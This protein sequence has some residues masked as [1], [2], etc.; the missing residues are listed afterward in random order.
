MKKFVHKNNRLLSFD[1]IKQFRVGLPVFLLILVQLVFWFPEL[2]GQ[3]GT[4]DK[5][6]LENKN[7]KVVLSKEW[8]AILEYQ[9]KENNSVILGNLRNSGPGISFYKGAETV[10]RNNTTI[11]YDVS[12]TNKNATYHASVT[13]E[14]QP[15]IE[16][17]LLYSLK[18]NE[19]EIIFNNVVE[20]R[21]FYLLNIQL[22]GLLTVT[23]DEN[24][25]KLVIP[26]DAGRLIDIENANLK[27]YEYEIDWLNPILVGFAYNSRVIGVMD[28]RSIENHSIVSVSESGG[29]RYGS[30]SMNIMHRLNEYNLEEFGTVIPVSDPE[31]LLKVQDS[32]TITISIAGDFDRD[33]EVSWIDGTKLIRD[34]I[35]AVPNPLYKDKTFVRTFVDRK[36]STREELTFNEV[37]ERI[38]QFAAQ[39]DSA[40]YVMYL[41]G[42][43]YT[44]HDTGYPS[45]DKVN[46]NLGGYDRLVNLIEEARKYN[47]I[48][49][50]YD[51]YDDSYPNHPGWDPDVIC[52][53]PQGSL[54]RGGAWDGEQS[55]L[56]SSYKYAVKSGLDR[57]RFTINRYP[58][59]QAYFIDVLAGGYNGGRKYD[60]NPESPAGAIKNFEGKLMLVKEF[61]K[62]GIDVAT[63]D[64]TGFFVGHVGT[65]G[66]IIAFDNIYFKGE[67][68]IPMIPFIYH[69]K[70]SFGMKTSS[71]SFYVRTFLYGQR[72]Q[73]FTNRR[74][75]F[76]P[77]DYILDALP[78]Q[79]LYGKSMKSY[80]RYGD[81]ERVV[82]EDGSVVEANV[83]NNTYSVALSDGLVIAM[84]YT[85][86]VPVKKN[87]FMACS[88]NG[89]IISYRIPVDWKNGKKINVFRVDKDG[90]PESI[91]FDLNGRCLE[92]NTESNMPYKV[93]YSE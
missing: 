50:F 70:T 54:M 21:N 81:F 37:L 62:N 10:M 34:K 84:N 36:G 78:K 60:F 19:I 56:I 87:V 18:D 85:S 80:E 88:R 32:C 83:K 13:Y 55:Y 92:F 89:G 20:H 33:G 77:G 38:K 24:H 46:E 48:V 57:V 16:F 39:T 23:S 64:F 66:D 40:A 29:R 43:Q 79:K 28:T 61:N 25:G 86:F 67:Q 1:L 11:K 15:A 6:T 71:S 4:A 41:L 52:V 3:S 17:D 90:S 82:Y 9:L 31:Y 49:T 42:W 72:A 45:V 35:N 69:G 75:V 7:I 91:E 22:P 76:T 51:N 44:G 58:V 65:F 74:S 26:A 93:I 73:D 2:F 47:V 30:F 5:I 8:P 63:E 68:Q 14:N 12:Y 53:D 59:R 27:S